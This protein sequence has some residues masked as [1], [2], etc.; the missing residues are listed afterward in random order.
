MGEYPKAEP[1]VQEALRIFR[2]VLGPE[3]PDTVQSLNNLASLDQAMGEFAKAETLYQEALRTRQKVFRPADPDTAKILNNLAELY[4]KMGEYAR[5]EPL[6]QEALRIWQKVLGQNIPRQCKALITWPSCTRI[7]ASSPKPNHFFGK[8]SGSV[9]R[10][11][12]GT[13]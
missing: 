7:W 13:S 2:K 3:H 6:L 8:L 10:F 1:L 11:W 4:N 12:A 5:A 9:K